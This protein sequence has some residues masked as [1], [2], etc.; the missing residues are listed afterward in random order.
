[1]RRNGRKSGYIN[2]P[3]EEPP[4]HYY[5]SLYHQGTYNE[6]PHLHTHICRICAL[7]F[8]FYNRRVLLVTRIRR[9]VHQLS[10]RKNCALQPRST[11][12]FWNVCAVDDSQSLDVG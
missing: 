4:R 5:I 11:T 2:L 6:I 7:G 1:M 3:N 8:W 12:L 10:Y 9:V